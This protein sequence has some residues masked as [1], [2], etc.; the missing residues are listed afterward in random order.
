MESG[1]SLGNIGKPLRNTSVFVVS[2]GSE[3]TVLPAGAVGELIFGG[4]QVFPGYLGRDDLNTTKLI[5]HPQH[6]RIYRSGDIGRVLNDGSLLI[7][8]RLDDQVKLRGNRVELGE[9]NAVMLRSHLVQDCTTLLVEDERSGQVL[10]AFWVP[11]DMTTTLSQQTRIADYDQQSTANL[12]AHL[13]D[14]LPGYMVPGLLIPI[15]RLPLTAQGKLDQRLLRRTAVGLD[16][17][18]REIFTRQLYD[19]DDNDEWS[20]DEEEI[21]LALANTLHMPRSEVQRTTSFFA[22]GLNSLTAIALA[23][24]IGRSLHRQV[25][26]DTV[27]RNPSVAR[28]GGAIATICP[29]APTILAAASSIFSEEFVAHVTSE[30]EARGATTESI[31]PCT[32][33]QEAMLSAA[34]TSDNQGSYQNA[35][36][37]KLMGDVEKMKRCWTQLVKRQAILRTHFID[38]DIAGYPFAQVIVRHKVLP[39][40]PAQEHH[41]DNIYNDSSPSEVSMLEPFRI[42]VDRTR[43]TITLRMHHE[44]YDGLS[45]SIMLQEIEQLYNSMPLPDPVSFDPFLSEALAHSGPEAM[46]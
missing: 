1:D 7:N 16:S 29:S 18:A 17:S 23:K 38:T 10:V 12:L 20:A 4:E 46:Q 40:Y 30:C 45:M 31:L 43:S 34:S 35:T 39:W 19:T 24:A 5:E 44:I 14:L 32:P 9:I 33:L 8:G 11:K 3:F 41:D 21:A 37:L 2:P 25:G 36:T 27:L 22:L 28:L 15:T 42:E 26:I 13:D 6:G